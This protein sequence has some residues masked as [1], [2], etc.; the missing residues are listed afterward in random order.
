MS[1]RFPPLVIPKP[2]EQMTRADWAEAYRN[3]PHKALWDGHKARALQE[4][5]EG[6]WL[7]LAELAESL[8]V[9]FP[10]RESG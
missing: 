5:A 2:P 7:T 8:G 1:D 10:G 4:L 6:K 3:D 9:P